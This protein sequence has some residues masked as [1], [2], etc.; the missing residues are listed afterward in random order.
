MEVKL[1]TKEFYVHSQPY[2]RNLLTL[3]RENSVEI[4]LTNM[5]TKAN[6]LNNINLF[7]IYQFKL[8]LLSRDFPV[9]LRIA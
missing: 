1:T 4:F 3:G 6:I 7:I 2:Q 9:C 5:H 8:N